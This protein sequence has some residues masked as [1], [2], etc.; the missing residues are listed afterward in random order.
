MVCDA[1]FLRCEKIILL[2]QECCKKIK[3]KIK[4]FND[5]KN[6][7]FSK[8]KQ[9]LLKA[10]FNNDIKLQTALFIIDLVTSHAQSKDKLTLL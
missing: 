1:I 6:H 5:L 3:Q 7:S 10:C 8:N 9:L 2:R 4:R